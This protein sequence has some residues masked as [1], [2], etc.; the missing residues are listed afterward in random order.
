M[1]G[2]VITSLSCADPEGRTEVQRS[3]SPLKNY[4]NIG[5]LMKNTELP[6]QHSMLGQLRKASKRHLNPSP[7][8][9]K[10]TRLKL[11]PHDKTF[12]IRA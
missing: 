8:Q 6:S 9:L 12:W 4:N 11:D 10:N 2:L 7:H 3:G 5:F 1:I